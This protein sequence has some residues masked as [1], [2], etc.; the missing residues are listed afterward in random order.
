MTNLQFY[1]IL[2]FILLQQDM[3]TTFRR[4]LGVIYGVLAALWIVV[5]IME[6]MK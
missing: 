2:A 6:K 4:I 5:D 1:L 3:D